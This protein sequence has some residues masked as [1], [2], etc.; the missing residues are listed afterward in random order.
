MIVYHAG[1]AQIV[2]D[3][4]QNQ[5]AD[6]ILTSFVRETG[7]EIGQREVCISQLTNRYLPLYFRR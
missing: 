6:G 7:H 1:K 4:M 2:D 5:I 3:V